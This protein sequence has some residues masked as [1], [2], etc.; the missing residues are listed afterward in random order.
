MSAAQKFHV[1][2]EPNLLRTTKWVPR[3]YRPVK[4]MLTGNPEAT[5]TPEPQTTIMFSVLAIVSTMTP[6][7]SA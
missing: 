5:V 3:L 4:E 2:V 1:E 7:R 6:K